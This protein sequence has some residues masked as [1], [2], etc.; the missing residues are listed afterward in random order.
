MEVSWKCHRSVMEAS[1]KCHGSVTEVSCRAEGDPSEMSWKCQGSV[2]D[3]LCDDRASHDK[4]AD[5]DLALGFR[6]DSV[7]D[8]GHEFEFELD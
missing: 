5:L 8:D 2:M 3:V 1:W 6:F 4:Y 7:L